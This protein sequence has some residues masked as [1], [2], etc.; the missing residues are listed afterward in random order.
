[1]FAN[2]HTGGA[3]GGGQEHVVKWRDAGK[4]LFLREKW[5]KEDL[6]RSQTKFLFIQKARFFFA[7][8]NAGREALITDG[9]KIMVASKKTLSSSLTYWMFPK[10][11]EAY[12]PCYVLASQPVSHACCCSSRALIT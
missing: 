6:K 2:V 1:M 9:G 3:G 8:H 4:K 11:R 10:V 12:V 7:A 5:K